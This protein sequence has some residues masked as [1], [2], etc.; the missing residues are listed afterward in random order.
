MRPT[1]R[2]RLAQRLVLP[3][4]LALIPVAPATAEAGEI[5]D[6][7][8]LRFLREVD[9]KPLATL[10]VMHKGRAAAL[11]S[12]AR[13]QLE[14]IV[15]TA[16]LAKL[17]PTVAYLELYFRTGA[18]LHKPVLYVR[19]KI[20]RAHLAD[21]LGDEAAETFARTHRL[22]PHWLLR[23]EAVMH[24]LRQQRL[25]GRQLSSL[26]SAPGRELGQAT[27][28]LG[29]QSEMRVPLARLSGRLEALLAQGVLR[30][31]ETSD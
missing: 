22:A 15:G 23:R 3:L 13:E 31:F 19:E 24:L 26:A 14:T 28:E 16:A 27:R 29:D 10:A 8:T 12:V 18:Y 21:Y 1:D 4:L 2:Q 5:F 11:D 6:D 30:L 25:T 9:P 7:D 17:P 20:M